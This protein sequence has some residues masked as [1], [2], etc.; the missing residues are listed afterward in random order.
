MHQAVTLVAKY[1]IFLSALLFVWAFAEQPRDK[2]RV[3]LTT[4]VIGV[5]LLFVLAKLGGHFYNDPR[6]FVA[7]R[8]TP[9]FPHGADNGFPSDHTLVASFA[10][11]LVL[12]Y[13]KKFG[14][15][16]LVLALLIGA[17][18]VQAGIHHW[19]DILGG[20]GFAAIS[21]WAANLITRKI[22]SKWSPTPRKQPS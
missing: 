3:L 17:S 19:I 2:K 7:G 22:V 9:Y 6:P 20:F 10:G 18:R 16:L 14:I 1:L 15:V 13:S 11:F 4:A 12:R 8:F 21:V 5:V